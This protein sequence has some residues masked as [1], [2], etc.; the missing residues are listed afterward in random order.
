MD[1]WSVAIPPLPIPKKPSVLGSLDNHQ[2]RDR[3]SAARCRVQRN[4]TE[5][6]RPLAGGKTVPG[7]RKKKQ[8]STEQLRLLSRRIDPTEPSKP[9]LPILYKPSPRKRLRVQPDNTEVPA[10]TFSKPTCTQL[11]QT[12]FDIWPGAPS[13]GD[14]TH[15]K[16]KD[17][18]ELLKVRLS[19]AKYRLLATLEAQGCADPL[20]E[21][22][23]NTDDGY[24]PTGFIGKKRKIRLSKKCNQSPY[25]VTV[26]NGINLNRVKRVVKPPPPPPPPAKQKRKPTSDP[27]LAAVTLQDGNVCCNLKSSLAYLC[28]GS[29]AYVCK[30]CNKKYKNRN[31]LVY[32]RDRCKQRK[33]DKAINC[34]CGEKHQGQKLV[35]CEACHLWSHLECIGMDEAELNNEGPFHCVTCLIPAEKYNA[36]PCDTLMQGP[37][38]EDFSLSPS[39][40]TAATPSLYRGDMGLLTPATTVINTPSPIPHSDSTWFEFANF[41]TDFTFE[42]SQSNTQ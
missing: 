21:Q 23:K 5:N 9:A 37:I 40:W 14:M 39:S 3:M 29:R 30:D 1:N 22:L 31:G 12:C 20:Y 13:L 26:G 18:S 11:Y 4:E 10:T 25:G 24:W 34:A 38:W 36:E 8:M 28:T 35:Q 6:H 33:P 7:K 27:A 16:V 42:D 2:R 41:D 19:Q 17:L 15:D 32:H